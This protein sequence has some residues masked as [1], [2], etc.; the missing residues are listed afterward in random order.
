LGVHKVPFEY[1]PQ[2]LVK[3]RIGGKSTSSLKRTFI[4][5]K[6]DLI[7]CDRHGIK[8]N[9]F[10]FYCKYLVKLLTLR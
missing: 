5:N 6:E 8:T 4:M 2:V 7:S 1:L 9:V 10:K 3:M